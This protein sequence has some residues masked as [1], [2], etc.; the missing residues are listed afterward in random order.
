MDLSKGKGGE[1]FIAPKDV[2]VKF[3]KKKVGQS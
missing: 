2:D 3:E 1:N